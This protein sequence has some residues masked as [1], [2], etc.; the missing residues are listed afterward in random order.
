M[1][2]VV[3]LVTI[4]L[5]VMIWLTGVVWGSSPSEVTFHRRNVG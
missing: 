4:G 2:L 5:R 1:A 3:S